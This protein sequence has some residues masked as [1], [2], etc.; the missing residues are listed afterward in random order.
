M[1]T[2]DIAAGEISGKV[3]ICIG[4]G[5]AFDKALVGEVWE[6]SHIG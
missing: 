6:V 5:R 4:K 1:S 3:R 2:S